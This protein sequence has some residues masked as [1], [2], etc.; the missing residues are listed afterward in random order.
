MP[1]LLTHAHAHT[2]DI[3][4]FFGFAQAC[5]IYLYERAKPSKREKRRTMREPFEGEC[6]TFMRH[7]ARVSFL[8]FF[9]YCMRGN[10]GLIPQLCGTCCWRLCRL[11][12]CIHIFMFMYIRIYTYIYTHVFYLSIFLSFF[13]SLSIY[14]SIYPSIHLYRY[15][16]HMYLCKDLGATFSLYIGF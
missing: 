12:S 7:C 15:T 5:H 9:V 13:L 16:I 3:L 14:L 2:H 8:Y 4:M 1:H 6:R 11:A 10:A